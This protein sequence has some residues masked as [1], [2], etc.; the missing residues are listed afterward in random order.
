ME[1]MILSEIQNMN[2][3][4]GALTDTSQVMVKVAKNDGKDIKDIVQVAKDMLNYILKNSVKD[5]GYTSLH[6]CNISLNPRTRYR[7]QINYKRHEHTGEVES[8]TSC[9]LYKMI[10]LLLGGDIETNPGPRQKSKL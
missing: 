3:K 8:D 9:F 7:K 10:L 4:V 2:V 6:L 5:R 1:A